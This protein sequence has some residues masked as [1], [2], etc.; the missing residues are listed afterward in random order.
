MNS[1]SKNNIKKIKSK[2]LKIKEHPDGELFISKPFGTQGNFLPNA[3]K[4]VKLNRHFGD[5]SDAPTMYIRFSDNKGVIEVWDYVPGPGPGDF[6]KEFNSSDEMTDFFIDYYFNKNPLFQAKIED[7]IDHRRAINVKEI[8]VL[9]EKTIKY[10]E[11]EYGEED[12]DLYGISFNKVLIENWHKGVF[13]AQFSET[14]TEHGMLSSEAFYL[15]RKRHEGKEIEAKNLYGLAHI[16]TEL[17][18]R[19]QKKEKNKV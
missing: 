10:L 14:T 9:F 3:R 13:L 17:S 6:T 18:I 12:I 4:R 7:D 2:G 15:K 16:L 19:G 11:E 8:K 1:L 5:E